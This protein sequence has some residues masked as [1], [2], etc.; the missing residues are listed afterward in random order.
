MLTG[1]SQLTRGTLGGSDIRAG[2]CRFIPACAGNSSKSMPGAPSNTVHPRLRGELKSIEGIDICWC[3]S[4]PLTRGT[5]SKALP[6]TVPRRF[7]PAYAG[8]SFSLSH[9]PIHYSVH[10]RLRGELPP[11]SSFGDMNIGSSPLT[12][13]TL[14]RG[15]GGVFPYPVHPCLRGEL[16]VSSFRSPSSPGSSPLTRGTPQQISG[17]TGIPRFIPAYAGN[18]AKLETEA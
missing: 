8:N 9:H 2:L 14:Y 17:A 12:R 18:S 4:S 13:G 7:I 5:Q 15:G 11:K 10:P 3:G 16:S 6:R 1:S